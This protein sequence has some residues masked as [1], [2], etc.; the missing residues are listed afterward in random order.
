MPEFTPTIKPFGMQGND[1]EGDPVVRGVKLLM[2][3]RPKEALIEFEDAIRDDPTSKFAYLGAATILF[4]ERK[5]YESLT[6]LQEV[7]RIDPFMKQPLGLMGRIYYKQQNYEQ[8]LEAFQDL[9][10]IDAKSTT[11]YLGIA[12]VHLKMG[13]HDDAI[14]QARKALKLNPQLA[15]AHLLVAHAYETKG[16]VAAA[17]D[18]L[19]SLINVNPEAPT[20][21]VELGRLYNKNERFRD[22]KRVYQTYLDANA[23]KKNPLYN[24]PAKLGL[25]EAMVGLNELDRAAEILRGLPEN[26]R[27]GP[28]KHKLLGD[29]FTLKGMYKEA[30]Q[31]YQSAT[32]L[33]TDEGFDELMDEDDDLFDQDLTDIAKWQELAT[34]YRASAV[35]RIEE[36]RN[37][38]PDDD[39][40]EG[41]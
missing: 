27:V 20:A 1:Q 32:I 5:F 9:A 33:A 4:R 16:N 37:R 30:S 34:S 29:I 35:A 12:Q 40:P 24:T 10:S 31:E 23:S 7:T 22:A 3:R 2:Q 39:E 38:D 18:Q 19:L 21:Y 15:P 28:E 11:P 6:Y 36:M 41:F 26:Q 8:A 14:R 17:V 13:Q 25:A